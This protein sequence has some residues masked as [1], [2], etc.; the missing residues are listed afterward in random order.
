VVGHP[1]RKYGWILAREPALDKTD[2]ERINAL[3]RE[4]GY[5]PEAFEPTVQKN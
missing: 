4:K 1:G 5:D 3:L 2:L